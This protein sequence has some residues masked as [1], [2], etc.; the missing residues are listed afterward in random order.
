MGL[1]N[2]DKNAKTVKGNKRGIMTGILYLAPAN[3]S[4]LNV[5]PHASKGCAAACLYTSG[6]GRYQ[7]TKDA[8]IK[9]TRALFADKPAFIAQLKK[10]I[11]L[12]MGRADRKGMDLAIR[13][14]GTSDLPWEA[15]FPMTEFPTVQFYDY[16]KNPFRMNKF[17]GHSMPENYHLT[18]S[19]SETNMPL[20]MAVLKMGGNV[21]MVFHTYD[22]KDF[23]K[24]HLGFRVVNGDRDDLRYKDPKNVIVALKMK[25]RAVHDKTGFVQS[26]EPESML[27]VA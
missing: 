26:C 2:F 19:L 8:R 22:V 21:A 6:H 20:A 9:K 17:L 14:N 3:E 1:L 13:F 16:T 11:K 7:R 24:T 4:G 10:E 27:A 15:F 25:G 18:F 12:A 5:C 23:P